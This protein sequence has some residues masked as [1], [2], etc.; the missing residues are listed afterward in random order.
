MLLSS[1][2]NIKE[3]IKDIVINKNKNGLITSLK[4]KYN[5]YD[6][7]IFANGDC[8]SFSWLE[9][10]DNYYKFEY[11]INNNIKSIEEVKID[12]ILPFSNIQEYDNNHM[13]IIKFN[14]TTEIFKFFLRNSSNGYY[15][16]SLY[17]TYE[18]K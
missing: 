13:F 6:I 14:N 1:F 4:L 8:C 18:K 11:L 12:K 9:E 15:D 16:G 3:Y 10:Y 2:A 5:S 17:I 7:I